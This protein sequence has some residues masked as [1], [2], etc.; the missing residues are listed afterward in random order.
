M[1]SSPF[2]FSHLRIGKLYSHRTRSPLLFLL[3]VSSYQA[4]H[5][6]GK[7]TLLLP[8]VSELGGHC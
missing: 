4:L 5:Y 3:D 2:L 8:Q 6:D 1:C 7:G